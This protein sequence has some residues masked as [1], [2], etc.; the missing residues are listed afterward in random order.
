MSKDYHFKIEKKAHDK[1]MDYD[2][3]YAILTPFFNQKSKWVTFNKK[4][5]RITETQDC[6]EVV[7]NGW[8]LDINHP[9]YGNACQLRYDVMVEL[10]KQYLDNEKSRD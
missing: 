5:T 9:K 3:S 2:T 10:N 6:L 4:A 8:Y 7:I 1:A